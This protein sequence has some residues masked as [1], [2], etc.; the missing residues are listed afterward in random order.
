MATVSLRKSLLPIPG[1]GAVNR[2]AS[3]ARQV[4]VAGDRGVVPLVYGQDRIGA[5]IL[6]VLRTSANSPTLLVHCLWAHACD[7]ITELRLNGS[8]LPAAATATHY[9]G[10]QTAVDETLAGAFGAQGITYTDTLAGYAYSVITLPISAFDGSLDITALVRGRRVYD[11]RLDGTAGGTG[12]QR[13][14][15]P[16]TWAW[17]DCPALAAADFLASS[18]YGAGEPVDWSTVPAAANANDGLVGSPGEKRRLLGVS[19]TE[20][21][22]VADIAEALRAYAGCWLVPGAAGMRL[23]PDVDAAPAATYAHA[24]GQI[25][26]IEPL[27]L[28]DQGNTPTA[29]EVTYTDTSEIPWR[30]ASA[31][32]TLTGAGSTRPWRLSVVKLPGIHRHSQAYREAVERLNRLTQ[33][34]ITTAVEVFDQGIQHDVG[35]I[36]AITH[37][38]GLVAQPMRVLGVEMPEAGR[39]KLTLAEH[40]AASYS[41]AV[42]TTPASTAP[43]R[44][45]TGPLRAV[46]GNPTMTV[47]AESD[48]TV[49]AWGGSGTT[50]TMVEGFRALRFVASVENLIPGSFTVGEPTVIGGNLTV[51]ARS[52]ADTLTCIVG[53]HSAAAA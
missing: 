51:G 9:T 42:V 6:S 49:I 14:A 45:I 26:A 15:T 43:G 38:V 1:A 46:V 17:S 52:G 23:L 48:G 2:A 22:A 44:S 5:R 27:R 39:W 13:L 16:S 10:S 53:N 8:A 4:A 36:I 40:D 11:P 32:A 28:R 35:D 18:V 12:P 30:E 20:P 47:P 21:A 34:D 25:A 50:L 3:A 33:T 29:V 7:S 41:N 24:S 31:T 37:P 19:F